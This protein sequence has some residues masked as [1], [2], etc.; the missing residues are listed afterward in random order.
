MLQNLVFK[1]RI[2]QKLAKFKDQS[3]LRQVEIL[4]NQDTEVLRKVSEG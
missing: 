2:R 3:T 4:E 1:V